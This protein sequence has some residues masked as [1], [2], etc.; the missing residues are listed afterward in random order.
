MSVF[1]R[2]C[3]GAER[4]VFA[5]DLQ[6]TIRPTQ[7]T[8]NRNTAAC[9]LVA[10]LCFWSTGRVMADVFKCQVDGKTIYSQA[11]CAA[12]AQ[13]VEIKTDS[14]N[15]F[16]LPQS[17]ALQ[18]DSRD[19]NSKD[20]KRILVEGQIAVHRRTLN[21]LRRVMELEVEDLRSQQATAANNLAGAAER[22]SLATEM[23]A[24][25]QRYGTRIDA[26]QRDIDRLESQ[27]RQ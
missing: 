25:T 22:Q 3:S 19:R 14:P 24:V 15:Q 23:T 16:E 1:D 11:P 18:N 26:V 10:E 20:N 8:M 9:M 2:P 27:L 6:L 7:S 13:K 4:K 21:N 5:L 17:T 12:D